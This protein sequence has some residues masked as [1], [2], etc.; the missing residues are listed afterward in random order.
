M[1]D[2]RDCADEGG[3]EH[4]KE[5][6]YARSR[7][8]PRDGIRSPIIPDTRAAPKKLAPG[9][10]RTTLLP[11]GVSTSPAAPMARVTA[12]N[13]DQGGRKPHSGAHGLNCRAATSIKIE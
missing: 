7:P 6:A 3:E 8:Q 2:A 9:E 1:P 11:S 10:T 12:G 4:E 5:H 13:P